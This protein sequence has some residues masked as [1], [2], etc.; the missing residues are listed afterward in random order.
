MSLFYNSTLLDKKLPGN[1]GLPFIGGNY[2]SFVFIFTEKALTF[3][4]THNNLLNLNI[5]ETMHFFRDPLDFTA[6]RVIEHGRIFK[7]QILGNVKSFSA[8]KCIYVSN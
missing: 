6:K 2:F 5:T 3:S 8:K 4:S 7:T 1:Y